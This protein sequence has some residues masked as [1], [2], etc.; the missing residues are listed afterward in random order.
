MII[1]KPKLNIAPFALSS[2]FLICLAAF[3]SDVLNGAQKGIEICLKN[4]IPSLFPF[5]FLGTFITS[6]GAFDF[7]FSAL[8]NLTKFLFC[9]P[10]NSGQIIFMSLFGGYPVGTKLVYD[11]LSRGEITKDE[12]KRMC[13]FCVNPGPAFTVTALG[14]GIY[15]NAKT[16]V[17]IFISLCISA[18]ITGLLTR[19]LKED[20]A[21]L[22][23]KKASRNFSA[24]DIAAAV[25]DSFESVLKVCAWV[26]LFSGVLSCLGDVFGERGKIISAFL[27]V[28]SGA[29]TIAKICPIEAVAALCGFG[30]LCVH[31]QIIK[32]IKAC[33]L[34]YR[35]FF[36]GRFFSA[37]MSAAV[38]HCILYYYPVEADV[39]YTFSTAR[40][41]AVS[42][43]APAVI[44]FILMCISMIFNVDRKKKVW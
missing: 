15:G 26:I 19:F 44:T 37:A 43:T 14:I 13:I 12:A 5:M 24:D 42:A 27:E 30:G 28:T 41:S 1:I 7:I 29:V 17:I 32:Y 35:L 21:V 18:I 2:A 22:P 16:G 34:T 11:A 6:T 39:A 8:R 3:P 20:E 33:G 36:A 40:T 25:G 38:C 31:C 10:E 4:L 23:Y 9:L